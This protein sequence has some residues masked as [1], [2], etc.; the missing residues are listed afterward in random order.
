MLRRFK[1]K[2]HDLIDNFLGVPFN[3]TLLKNSIIIVHN[4]I[5]F[6]VWFRL[7]PLQTEVFVLMLFIL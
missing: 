6:N 1:I 2:A 5:L 3:P 7:Q 4:M